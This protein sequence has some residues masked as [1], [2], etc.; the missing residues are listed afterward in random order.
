M[1]TYGRLGYGSGAYGGT[2]TKTASIELTLTEQGELTVTVVDGSGDALSDAD[3]TITG[4]AGSVDKTLQTD[5]SGVAVFD[6]LPI[7]DYTVTAK[8]TGYFAEE[9]SVGSGDFTTP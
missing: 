6:G 3:V 9:V 1:P 4:A 2:M 8:K 5:D 7:A